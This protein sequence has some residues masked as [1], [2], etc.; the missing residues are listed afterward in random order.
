[1]YTLFTNPE[2]SAP[3]FRFVPPHTYGFPTNRCANDAT[4]L[5][6]L[7]V[8]PFSFG[9]LVLIYTYF[10]STYPVFPPTL[11]FLQ[12]PLV[13]RTVTFV[14]IFN[15]L[16]VFAFLDFDFLILHQCLY[17]LPLYPDAAK[18][19]V[20]DDVVVDIVGVIVVVNITAVITA[21]IVIFF[22]IFIIIIASILFL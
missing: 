20:V 6:L 15:F 3:V 4:V 21:I 10:F 8:L 2:Q 19:V 13:E 14:P 11:I 12:L 18:T 7:Y 16:I 1:M 17:I 5:P 22:T 9:A